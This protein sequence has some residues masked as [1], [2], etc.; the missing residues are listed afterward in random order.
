LYENVKFCFNKDEIIKLFKDE[1]FLIFE[2]FQKI[3]ENKGT[4]VDEIQ[5]KQFRY[6][7]KYVQ[8]IIKNFDYINTKIYHEKIEEIFKF[9]NPNKNLKNI[10]NNNIK[11]D[12]K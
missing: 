12:V 3:V 7:M 10:D 2:K 4:I 5:L 8:K 11:K 9:V 6:E 1:F